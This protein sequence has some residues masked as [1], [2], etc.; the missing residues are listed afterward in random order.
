MKKIISS[1]VSLF[2]V[3]G[4][5]TAATYTN[6]Q[7]SASASGLPASAKGGTY[8][9][10][11]TFD[12]A[13]QNLAAADKVVM[14]TIPAGTFVQNVGYVLTTRETTASA[15]INVGDSSST[16]TWVSAT[17]ITNGGAA[18]SWVIGA[19]GTANTNSGVVTLGKLYTAADYVTIQPQ[20]AAVKAKLTVKAI[21]VP[22]FNQ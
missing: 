18:Y 9:L 13:N 5:A 11:S 7:G 1:L 15:T 4:V 19:H 22:L 16:S 14:L 21:C 10:E 12:C 2:A 3:A 6:F 20:T 8:V 17:S